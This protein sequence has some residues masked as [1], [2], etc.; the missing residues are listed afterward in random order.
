MQSKAKS[1]EKERC[2]NH[3]S[4]RWGGFLYDTEFSKHLACILQTV[5]WLLADLI[6]DKQMEGELVT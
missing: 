4:K 5:D 3:N 1:N 6:Y 2:S